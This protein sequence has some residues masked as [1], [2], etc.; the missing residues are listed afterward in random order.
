MNYYKWDAD[1]W[2]CGVVDLSCSPE[3]G[4]TIDPEIY[5][6]CGGMRWNGSA[7]IEYKP[8]DKD[9]TC[10]GISEVRY[11]LINSGISVMMIGKTTR[12]INSDPQSRDTIRR[13]AQDFGSINTISPAI[14]IKDLYD[15][16]F[17]ITLGSD[18]V[19]ANGAI[20]GDIDSLEQ[21]LYRME[22]DFDSRVKAK[23]FKNKKEATI[24]FRQEVLE[25]LQGKYDNGDAI[26]CPVCLAEQLTQ[27]E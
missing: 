17:E 12:T 15:D 1:G 7:W 26:A 13:L 11:N 19:N 27:G 18:L 20:Q 2:Y 5:D 8:L 3:N 14:V 24:A 22:K 9:A 21:T 25:Y 4:T 6:E 10:D 16:F 23:E